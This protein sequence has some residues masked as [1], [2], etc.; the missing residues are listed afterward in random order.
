MPMSVEQRQQTAAEISH[1]P[2][3]DSGMS[4]ETTWL[5][6]LTQIHVKIVTFR[7]K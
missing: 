5:D 6:N 4:R 1:I 3:A 2:I 7:N